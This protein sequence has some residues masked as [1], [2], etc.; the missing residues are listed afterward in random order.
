MVG[1]GN[2]FQDEF[3]IEKVEVNPVDVNGISL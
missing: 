2:V 3:E 1:Q